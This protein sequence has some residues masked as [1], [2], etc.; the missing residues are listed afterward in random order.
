[1]ETE[2]TNGCLDLLRMFGMMT[3]ALTALVVLSAILL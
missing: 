2:P 1:M 3:L